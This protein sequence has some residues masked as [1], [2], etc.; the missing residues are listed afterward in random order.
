MKKAKPNE[1]DVIGILTMTE[2]CHFCSADTQWVF[3]LIEH[4]VVDPANG[5][6]SEYAFEAV[7]VLRAKKAR[8]LERD[9]GI[10]MAGIALVLDLLEE[11]DQLRRQLA[12]F[13]P[14]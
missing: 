8:R 13:E 11:R 9:L 1:T 6:E 4:G 2:L 10:N 14:L 3:E 12:Q 7:S 5:P